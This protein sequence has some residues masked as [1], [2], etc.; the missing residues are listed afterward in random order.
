[1]PQPADRVVDQVRGTA[2]RLRDRGRSHPRQQG[3]PDHGVRRPD[4]GEAVD[5]EADQPGRGHLVEGRQHVGGPGEQGGVA[6]LRARPEHGHRPGEPAALDGAARQSLAHAGRHLSRCREVG[7]EGGPQGPWELGQE[8]HHVPGQ[9]SGVPGESLRHERVEGDAVGRRQLGH[10]SGPQGRQEH[11]RRDAP[12]QQLERLRRRVADPGGRGQD[13]EQRRVVVVPDRRRQ[14]LERGGVGPVRVVDDDQGW[15]RAAVARPVDED[16]C[17]RHGVGRD[18]LAGHQ[19][20]EDAVRHVPPPRRP[21]GRP[22]PGR[23]D[24]PPAVRGRR[25]AR[26]PPGRSR[27]RAPAPARGPGAAAAPPRR[28]RRHARPARACHGSRAHGRPGRAGPGGVVSPGHHR[29]PEAPCR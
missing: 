24:G 17:G 15:P 2:V 11:L 12:A 14:R 10:R 6:Y 19:L 8:L 25:C 26:P 18:V 16:R 20:T 3:R 1:M 13:D 27:A 29:R 9:P 21:P 22:G 7:V 28:A 5:A 23:R 4:L